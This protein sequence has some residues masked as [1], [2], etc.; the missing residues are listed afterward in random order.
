MDDDLKEKI[1]VLA[2]YDKDTRIALRRD[3][4]TGLVEQGE[5]NIG[6]TMILTETEDHLVSVPF[7][8]ALAGWL[9][10]RDEP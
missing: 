10:E 6:K 2:G 3:Q 9:K 4:I 8:E 5:P 7:E 1:W